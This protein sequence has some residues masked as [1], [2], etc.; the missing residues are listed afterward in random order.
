MVNL[1][2]C[3]LSGVRGQQ[4]HIGLWSRQTELRLTLCSWDMADFSHRCASRLSALLSSSLPLRVPSKVR[5]IS[6]G[7]EVVNGQVQFS[8]HSV[9]LSCPAIL[10]LSFSTSISLPS[11]SPESL[12]SS[13]S[14]QLSFGSPHPLPMICLLL[15]SRSYCLISS[16][17]SLFPWFPPDSSLSLPSPPP[18]CV[19]SFHPSIPGQTNQPFYYSVSSHPISWACQQQAFLGCQILYSYVNSYVNRPAQ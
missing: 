15:P 3:G 14:S 9:P 2:V 8:T 4:S 16:C 1:S 19:W 10:F 18:S 17:S 7:S 6:Y 11:S 12:L 13:L 5:M